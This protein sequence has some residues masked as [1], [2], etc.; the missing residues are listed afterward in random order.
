MNG[1]D[2]RVRKVERVDCGSG[3]DVTHDVAEPKPELKPEPVKKGDDDES[4]TDVVIN[5]LDRHRR[6]KRRWK[7]IRPSCS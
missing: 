7:G 3:R 2:A 5:V 1:G 4:V 6:M